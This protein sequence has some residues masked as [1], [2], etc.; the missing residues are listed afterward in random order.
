[1]SGAGAGAG[2]SAAPAALESL[3]KD[4]YARLREVERRIY[5][6]ETEYF[7]LSL[8]GDSAPVF[9][10]L[11]SGWEGLLEGKAPDKRRGAERIFSGAREGGGRGAARRT[12]ARGCDR[13]GS[14]YAL[15][16]PRV[17]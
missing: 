8:A 14:S 16:P 3:E 12:R 6:D 13:A 7:K 15:A 11:V 17:V 1:M 5:T 10:N 9:G 2:A 4:I